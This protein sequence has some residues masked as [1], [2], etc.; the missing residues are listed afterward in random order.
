MESTLVFL[1]GE[2][3]DRG[4]WRATVHGVTT[5]QTRLKQFSMHTG[6]DDHVHRDVFFD[7]PSYLKKINCFNNSEIINNLDT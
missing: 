2:S 4:A 3:V 7:L 5:S 1:P 6:T